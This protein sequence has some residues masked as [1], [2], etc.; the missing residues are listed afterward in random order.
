[1]RALL[2]LIVSSLSVLIFGAC[3]TGDLS[4]RKFGPPN[5]GGP[6]TEE[7][8]AQIA[9]EQTGNFYYG[10]RYYVEKTRFW[11]YLRKPRQSANSSQLVIFNESKKRTPDRFSET[12]SGNQRYGYDQN[13]EY[14]IHGFYTGKKVY[15]VNSNQ[16]LPEF[17]L[18]G[19]EVV[20]K[21]PGW[22]F[23]PKDHFNPRS[24]TLTPR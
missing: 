1:M 5:M 15:E 6:S 23:S 2:Y 20:N 13:Y 12:G 19:Y 7:R 14:R 18:T 24:F 11:G 17:M 21:R 16:I 8:K 9:S 4:S 22:L 10:R 3:S